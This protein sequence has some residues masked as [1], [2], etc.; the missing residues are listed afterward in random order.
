[1]EKPH[2]VFALLYRGYYNISEIVHA[3]CQ[4]T[5]WPQ[6]H[7]FPL[8]SAF[9][10]H[11]WKEAPTNFSK[12]IKMK[13]ILLAMLIVLSTTASALCNEF[14]D[15]LKKAEQGDADAQYS[16]AMMYYKGKGVPQDY[17]QA[18]HW[19]TKAAEQGNADAQYS[20][21][22]M[23]DKGQGVPQDYEQAVYWY[24]KSAEQ[25][26]AWAQYNLGLMYAK[27]DGVSQ[28]H[29]QAIYWFTK[30]AEQGDA[31]AQYGL[32]VMYAKGQGVTQNYKLAYVWQ[33]LA[34]GQGHESAIKNKDT[35][36]KKLTSQQLSEAQ[37]LAVKIQY[38]IDK[39]TESKQ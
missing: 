24:T 4:F 12:E 19:W 8:H 39:P 5:A 11:M 29:K 32:G 16:L 27:G 23:Y 2:N 22:W 35:T 10:C 1:M 20:L 14:E 37:E 13:K 7:H 28:D 30:A 38:Q 33:S 6:H 34:A 31:D 17:E 36:A 15:A 18:V 3:D 21:G 9:R 25:G 26:D